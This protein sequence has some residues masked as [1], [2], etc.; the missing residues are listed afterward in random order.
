MRMKGLLHYL[1]TMADCGLILGCTE[2]KLEG[3]CDSDFAADPDKRHS[4][5]GC[6]F[7]AGWKCNQLGEQVVADCGHVN[8]GGRV[9]GKRLGRQA[10]GT[11]AAEAD[12]N[13]TVRTRSRRCYAAW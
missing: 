10:G 11:L 2:L 9:H 1:R 6:V 13:I 4:T 8:P 7:S 12:D 5:G 3:Y